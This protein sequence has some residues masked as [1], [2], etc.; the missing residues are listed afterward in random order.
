ML[1]SGDVVSESAVRSA[2]RMVRLATSGVARSSATAFCDGWGEL[3]EALLVRNLAAE[4]RLMADL[5]P[6][7]IRPRIAAEFVKAVQI[8]KVRSVGYLP[9][10]QRLTSVIEDPL[11]E[12]ATIS[13][14]YRS[15]CPGALDALADAL[16]GAGGA[17]R[18]VS[19]ALHR[20]QG[21]IVID[22]L[23]VVVDADLVVMDLVPGDGSAGLEAATATHR[24]DPLGSAVDAA[25]SLLAQAAHQGL[26]RLPSTFGGRLAA[27]A[28]E[29]TRCGLS[30]AG[31]GVGDLAAALGPDPDSAAVT[32]WADAQIRLS[33]TDE[34]L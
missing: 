34:C 7:L 24:A 29:L 11:G 21:G 26:R 15:A 18:Y 14:A 23:A 5:P 16:G 32:A 25:L 28:T 1:A 20:T 31:A 2:S 6:R 9:G 4:G 22:P 8:G 27:A 33:V 10:D 3:P 17:P 12:C 19:G 30:R 13:A